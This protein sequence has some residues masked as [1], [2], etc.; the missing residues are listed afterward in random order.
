MAGRRNQQ[1]TLGVAPTFH[2]SDAIT[3]PMTIISFNDWI[4]E[5]ISELRSDFANFKII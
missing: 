1:R 3:S 4:M 2:S 5:T